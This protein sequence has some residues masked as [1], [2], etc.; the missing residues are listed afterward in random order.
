MIIIILY[1]GVVQNS[2]GD[3]THPALEGIYGSD[4]NGRPG[5]KSVSM[6]T[7]EYGGHAMGTGMMWKEMEL[8]HVMM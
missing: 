6:G 5:T 2:D 3:P 8:V 4:S 7:Q 1:F